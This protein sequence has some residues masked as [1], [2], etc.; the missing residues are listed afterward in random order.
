LGLGEALMPR[1]WRGEGPLF[2]LDWGGREWTLRVGGSQPGLYDSEGSVGPLLAL[3]GLAETGRWAPAALSGATLVRCERHFERV[4]AT[5]APLGW[6]AA[7]VRAA[8]APV[9]QFGVDLQVQANA[10]T[11]AQL[12]AF[13]VR[14][15][16]VWPEP[17]EPLAPPPKWVEPRDAHCAALSYD[18]REPEL[19]RLTT[20]PPR[21][22]AFLSPRLVP[23]GG[24]DL[25][26][27]RG[28]SDARWL[29][30]E[31]VHPDDVS[32][33]IREGGRTLATAHTTRYALF[34]QDLEKGVVLRGRFRGLWLRGQEGKQT[35]LAEL[36]AFLEAPP[37]LGP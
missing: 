30:A 26:P 23:A 32:R 29:Y 21:R 1:H 22:E 3:D 17:P 11:V 14:I 20:L 34:G 10:F 33:R 5:Y 2:A 7:V 27:S 16:S 8:W 13:E 19:K 25:Q 4:E 37:P 6:G 28:D 31:M 15:A 35:A 9:G 18:G 12:H 36:Q 24:P